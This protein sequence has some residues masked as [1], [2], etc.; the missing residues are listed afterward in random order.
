MPDDDPRFAVDD[1]GDEFVTREVTWFGALG[2]E[3]LHERVERTDPDAGEMAVE[4]T[5][6]SFCSCGVSPSE[7]DRPYKCVDCTAI[8]CER[9]HI[10]WSRKTYCPDCAKRRWAVDKAVFYALW[11]LDEEVRDVDDLVTVE[12]QDDV[13]VEVQIEGPAAVLQEHDYLEDDGSLSTDGQEALSVGK[14][15]YDDDAD[16]NAIETRLRIQEV[17]NQR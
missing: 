12:T 13:P 8:C 7:T 5:T 4:E 11:F 16:V 15:L 17:A 9:C 1:G 2:S 3:K 6:I 14:Q 10:R